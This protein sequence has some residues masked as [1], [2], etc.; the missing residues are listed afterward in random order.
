MSPQRRQAK[1]ASGG[2]TVPAV[3]AAFALRA[4][5]GLANGGFAAGASA[6]SAP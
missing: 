4:E 5:G 6:P 3:T 2:S 1:V